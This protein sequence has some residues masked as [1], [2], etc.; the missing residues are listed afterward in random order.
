MRAELGHRMLCGL[1]PVK[2][3]GSLL[4]TKAESF[5]PHAGFLLLCL[6]HSAGN[7]FILLVRAGLGLWKPI[8]VCTAA[9]CLHAFTCP[10]LLCFQIHGCFEALQHEW[11]C[12]ETFSGLSVLKQLPLAGLGYACINRGDFRLSSKWVFDLSFCLCR[13]EMCSTLWCEKWQQTCHFSIVLE[14]R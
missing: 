3:L 13:L 10:L 14:P 6:G 1:V 11:D 9:C 8:L 5:F 7:E 4:G 12:A 2:L